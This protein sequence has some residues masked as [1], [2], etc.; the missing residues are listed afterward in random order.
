VGAEEGDFLDLTESKGQEA[1][2]VELPPVKRITRRD[3]VG[4]IRAL[5]GA[6]RES[7]AGAVVRGDA[8]EP[9][10][11]GGTTASACSGVK[12][13]AFIACRRFTPSTNSMSR[14]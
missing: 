8:P 3:D 1:G 13:P 9:K 7:T 11:T 10:G 6:L 14:K 5:V 2:Q 12:R 4:E